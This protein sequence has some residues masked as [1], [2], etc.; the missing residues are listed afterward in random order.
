[1]R[2]AHLYIRERKTGLTPKPKQEKKQKKRKK[3][4]KEY[5]D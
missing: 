5:T 3:D 1:M 2:A 4:T